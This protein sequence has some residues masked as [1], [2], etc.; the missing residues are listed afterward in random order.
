MRFYGSN[1][2]R[3]EVL[4]CML[5]FGKMPDLNAVNERQLRRI[6]AN[7]LQR[8][9]QARWTAVTAL[10]NAYF[11]SAD[12]TLQLQEKFDMVCCGC[13]CFLFERNGWFIGI[14]GLALFMC[15]DILRVQIPLS[16]GKL[17]FDGCSIFCLVGG[18]FC[19]CCPLAYLEGSC[20]M[21]YMDLGT[22]LWTMC[23]AG[24]QPW[25]TSS[26]QWRG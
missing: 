6:I 8:N 19:C 22:Q 1:P 21:E 25:L 14:T 23:S 17:G 11:R 10:G 15:T 26:W 7:A 13:E 9:P 16:C 20:A 12:D 4:Q 18:L 3:E 5:G 2:A 24:G